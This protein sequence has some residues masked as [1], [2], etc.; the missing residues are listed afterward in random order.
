MRP[1]LSTAEATAAVWVPRLP[2]APATSS[3][4]ARSC[5]QSWSHDPCQV[6]EADYPYV[7]GTTTNDE[8]CQYDLASVSPV[9]SITGYNNLPPNDQDAIMAH[10][11][12]VGGINYCCC[13]VKMSSALAGWSPR[14]LCGCQH[15]QG[16]PRRRLLWLPVRPEHPTQPRR[17]ARW[18]RLRLQPRRRCGLLARQEQLGRVLGREWLHQV[19]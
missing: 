16:L 13:S 17:P 10:I 8:D 19:F 5:T 14:H 2:S 18:I 15:L 7:S 4:S 11:A 9:A 6:S 12:N 3:S 1:T